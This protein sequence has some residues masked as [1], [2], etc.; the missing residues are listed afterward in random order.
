MRRQNDYVQGAPAVDLVRRHSSTAVRAA[1]DAA[2]TLALSLEN[3]DLQQNASTSVAATYL[4]S[5]RR[6]SRLDDVGRHR[7]DSHGGGVDD[8]LAYAFGA[9]LVAATS[10]TRSTTATHVDP[11][12]K[13]FT[14]LDRQLSEIIMNYWIN[15][16]RH[17]Y[18]VI[19]PQ[20]PF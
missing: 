19:P 16:I 12:T 3:G 2:A 6:P 5:F 13:S 14:R 4:Y 20:H 18:V 17:G 15:F 7:A 9:P 10:A 1:A 11:F 8:D